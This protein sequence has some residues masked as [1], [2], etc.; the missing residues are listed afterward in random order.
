MERKTKTTIAVKLT[1]LERQLLA[2]WSSSK[3]I[4]LPDA[5]EGKRNRWKPVANRLAKKLYAQADDLKLWEE[6][7]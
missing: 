1:R 7:P 2:R 3:A 6:R 4:E 5:V